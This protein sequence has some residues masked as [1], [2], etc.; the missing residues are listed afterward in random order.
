MRRSLPSC[1]CVSDPRLHPHHHQPRIFKQPLDVERSLRY[2]EEWL[3]QPYVEAVGPGP[4]HWQILR[5]L[6][7][8]TG[9]GGNLT[10]DAHIAALALEHGYTVCSTDHD[11]KRFPG[12]VHANPL[13]P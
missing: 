13:G 12:I 3:Q 8:A 5:S 4:K 11:F 1:E 2:V 7:Q 9:A 6:L 10:S